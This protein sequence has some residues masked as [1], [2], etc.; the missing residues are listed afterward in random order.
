MHEKT[1]D[2]VRY[3]GQALNPMSFLDDYKTNDPF[4]QGSALANQDILSGM[5]G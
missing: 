4:M 1:I 3:L 5:F 2:L